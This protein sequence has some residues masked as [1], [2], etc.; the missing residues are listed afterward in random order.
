MNYAWLWS[1]KNRAFFPS[2][3]I[4][5]YIDA[6]WDLSDAVE[7]SNELRA[8]YGGVWPQ[9]KVLSSRNGMPAWD[10][11]P[12]PTPEELVAEA[13]DQRKALIAEASNII[14]PMRDA[15]DGGYIDEADKP[16]LVAW[17]KYRYDLTKVD[18]AKPVWPS[19]PE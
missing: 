13:T 12:P 16:R 19:K 18:P 1:A 7:V 15:L 17:Q 6:G 8:E 2:E 5:G 3:K 9:G 11:L 4:Q 14:A 10:D